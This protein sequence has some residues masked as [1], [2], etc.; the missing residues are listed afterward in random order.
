MSFISKA[1]AI[2]DTLILATFLLAVIASVTVYYFL[3][4]RRIASLEEKINY[5]N[6]QRCSPMEYVKFQDIVEITKNDIVSEGMIV[7]SDEIFVSGISVTGYPFPQASRDEQITTIV[8]AIAF[9][10][11]IEKPIQLRQSTTSLDLSANIQQYEEARK[12]QIEIFTELQRQESN[13]LLQAE[14]LSEDIDVLERILKNIEAVETKIA[15]KKWLIK[16]IDAIIEYEK[17]LQSTSHNAQQTHQIMFSYVFQKEQ[18]SQELTREEIYVKAISE[19]RTKEQI[20]IGALANCGYSAASLTASE[21]TELIRRHLHPYTADKESLD[22]LLTDT[23][24][25][26]LFVTSNS[27]YEIEKERIKEE[28]LLIRMQMEE[29]ERQ[30][31]MERIEQERALEIQKL[32][33]SI[34]A[35]DEKIITELAKEMY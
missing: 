5:Q 24:I 1:N 21:L 31:E 13:L 28:L 20:F 34:E 25:S 23:S 2:M 15:S 9:A 32:R 8:N 30:K 3:K 10:N 7:I 18:F 33:A 4:V 17:L 26:E 11:I 6:F 22:S 16:E 12:K 27:L 14:N 19:L 35:F 29:E